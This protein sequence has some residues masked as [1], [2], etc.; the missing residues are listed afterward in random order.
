MARL[1]AAVPPAVHE[2]CDT[3]TAAGFEAVTVGGAVRDVLLGRDGGD[4]DVATSAHPDEVVARFARTIPTGMAHGTVTVIAGRGAHRLPI[5]VT[6]YRGDGAYVD[7]RRPT[8]VVFGVPLTEDLARR[9]LVVNAIAYDPVHARLIDPF[10]GRG[11][12]AARRLRA[13]GDPAARFAEDG[14]RIMRAIRFAATLEF[15]LDPE[16]TAAI[17]GALPS[18]AK[19]SRERVKV[20]LDKLLGARAPGAAL[21]IARATGVLAQE[22]PEAD[23]DD[24]GWPARVAWLERAPAAA[25]LAVLVA[26]GGDDDASAAA[27][28]RALRRL[29]AANDERDRAVRLVRLA[30]HA[31]A[32]PAVV[33]RALARCGRAHAA[34][35]VALWRA[36]GDAAPAVADAGEA[37]LVRGDALN[38]GELALTGAALMAALGLA[39][40]PAVGRALAACLDAV[41]DDP[42]RNQPDALIA[43]ARAY[44]DGA[45]PA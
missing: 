34:L 16:T 13:V 45:A 5:E 19:V 38:A 26:G 1:A 27:A 10:D 9:D 8:S 4:W 29:K 35:A 40:G 32:T 25:R 2:V 41:L 14:L 20:E 24:A 3:L 11:D 17:P 21:T 18:L 36:R 15:A 6:T 42:A 39:P 43:I 30:H 33:R 44:L 37:I 31:D 12:L 23:V 22:L 28:E 7:G